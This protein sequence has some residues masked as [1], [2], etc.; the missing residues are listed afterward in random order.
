MQL[1]GPVFVEIKL[2]NATHVYPKLEFGKENQDQE[3]LIDRELYN[4]IMELDI[5]ENSQNMNG[6]G[7][8]QLVQTFCVLLWFSNYTI[9]HGQNPSMKRRMGWV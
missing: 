2:R 9:I 6:G 7:Y 4:Y 8:E 1:E 3:P 5:M